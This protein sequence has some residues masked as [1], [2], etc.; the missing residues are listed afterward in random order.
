VKD[1]DL[2]DMTGGRKQETQFSDNVI[3]MFNAISTNQPDQINAALATL[4]RGAINIRGPSGYTPL[5]EAVLKHRVHSVELLLKRGANFRMRN[6]D[7]FDALD[8]AAFGGCA[9][10]ADRLI[11]AGLDPN[12]VRHDGFNTLHRAIWG[13]TPGHT[14]TVRVI[15]EAG[16]SPTKIANSIGTVPGQQSGPVH[17]R[18]MVSE[19]EAT[20]KLL[21][22][23]ISKEERHEKIA[24]QF[25]STQSAASRALE[26]G[27]KKKKAKK[28]VKD[29]V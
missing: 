16:V 29:E 23:W 28:A 20:A 18:D 4:P 17:P 5:F 7:G 12:T 9:M 14:E 21:E 25:E 2:I 24:Q 19:N 22:E 26:A 6:D 10:C 27:A 3:K 11:K 8:A 13:D 15:L 1:G